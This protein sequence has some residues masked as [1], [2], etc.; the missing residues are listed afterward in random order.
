MGRS[1][2]HSGFAKNRQR[3]LDADL[4]REFLS[5]IV[6]Q[7]RRQSARGG[8]EEHFGVDGTLL[9]SLDVVEEFPA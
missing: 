3:L 6:G 4:A 9:G 1:F 8:S 5:E 7:A 2:D